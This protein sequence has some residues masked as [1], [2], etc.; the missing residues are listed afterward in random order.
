MQA[1]SAK[2]SMQAA[3]CLIGGGWFSAARSVYLN[4][5]KT[6]YLLRLPAVVCEIF[7][8]GEPKKGAFGDKKKTKLPRWMVGDLP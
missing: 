4:A 3:C 1:D 7:R 2:T 8:N 5:T 6:R